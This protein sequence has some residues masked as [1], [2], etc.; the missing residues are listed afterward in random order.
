MI[1]A[2]VEIIASLQSR[3]LFSMWKVEFHLVTQSCFSFNSGMPICLWVDL[4]FSVAIGL[5]LKN[6]TMAFTLSTVGFTTF[7][8]SL[9][10]KLIVCARQRWWFHLQIFIAFVTLAALSLT[11]HL[12]FHIPVFCHSEQLLC[13]EWQMC[14]RCVFFTELKAIQQTGHHLELFN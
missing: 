14:L 3:I 13:S 12:I 7:R 10:S 5:L 11:Q 8:A 1:T 9:T 4:S 6:S 2:R